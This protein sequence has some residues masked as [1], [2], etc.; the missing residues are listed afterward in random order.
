MINAIGSNTI[1]GSKVY[2]PFWVSFRAGLPALLLLLFLAILFVFISEK[3][4]KKFF[5]KQ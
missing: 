5:K 3:I 2:A 4:D 1:F